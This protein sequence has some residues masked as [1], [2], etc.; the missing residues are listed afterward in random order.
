MEGAAPGEEEEAV[1]NHLEGEQGEE[2]DQPALSPPNK[3]LCLEYLGSVSGESSRDSSYSMDNSSEVA[4]KIA[5]IYA[6]RLMSDVI[7]VVGKIMSSYECD[8]SNIFFRQT[9]VGSP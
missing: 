7:L 1:D 4:T 9:G 8:S 3:R 5:G 6:E 2:P